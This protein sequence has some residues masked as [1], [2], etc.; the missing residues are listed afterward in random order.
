VDLWSSAQDWADG[1]DHGHLWRTK[2]VAVKPRAVKVV[3][4]A[5]DLVGGFGLCK[6]SGLEGL[7]REARPGRL[8]PANALLTRACVAQTVLGISMDEQSH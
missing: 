6:Q 3:E 8:S 4:T 5:L 2:L 1:V 7:F